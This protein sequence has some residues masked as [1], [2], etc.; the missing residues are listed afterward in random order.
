MKGQKGF[1]AIHVVFLLI[2]LG[3]VATGYVFYQKSEEK[4]YNAESYMQLENLAMKFEDKISIAESTPRIG[5]GAALNDLAT[6]KSDVSVLQVSDCLAPAK[7]SLSDYVTARLGFMSDFAAD[8]IDANDPESYQYY[9]DNA[10]VSQS[11]YLENM[12]EC[13]PS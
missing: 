3:A 13:Q 9:L 12:Q 8:K 7:T 2:I 1:T 5:L 10:Q 4:K 11:E 6:I